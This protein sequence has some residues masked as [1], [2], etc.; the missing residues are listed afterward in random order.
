M[1]IISSLVPNH[2][3]SPPAT[4][5]RSELLFRKDSAPMDVLASSGPVEDGLSPRM[6]LLVEWRWEGVKA[7]VPMWFG[8]WT[9][10]ALSRWHWCHHLP[11]CPEISWTNLVLL[12]PCLFAETGKDIK[13]QSFFS[14]SSAHLFSLTVPSVFINSPT[15]VQCRTTFRT[16]LVPS[17]TKSC[18]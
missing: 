6:S 3:E 8:V 2:H 11:A 17:A 10:R 1:T 9:A 16:W 7:R 4:W 12:F 15:E 5:G 13:V 14:C 18:F